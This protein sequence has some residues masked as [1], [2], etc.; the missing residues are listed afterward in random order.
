MPG[1]IYL[2][3]DLCSVLALATLVMAL[4]IR[5]LY[6]GRNNKLF[7]ILCVFLTITA[8]LDIVT[9]YMDHFMVLIP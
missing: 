1:Y 9:E 6:K 5:R 2:F 8:I 3:Y 4:C 7:L